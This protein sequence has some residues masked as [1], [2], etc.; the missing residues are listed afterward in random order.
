MHGCLIRHEKL[1]IAT[2]TLPWAVQ[3]RNSYDTI[4]NMPGFSEL[5]VVVL[6]N[7]LN[8]YFSDYAGHDIELVV[9]P[10]DNA[11]AS[12]TQLTCLQLPTHDALFRSQ[13]FGGHNQ[14]GISCIL[15]ARAYLDL[16]AF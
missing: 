10:V 9:S 1:H 6:T 7:T 16:L 3:L 4:S 8:Q 14:R 15:R 11:A 13:D 12:A 5:D 2:S